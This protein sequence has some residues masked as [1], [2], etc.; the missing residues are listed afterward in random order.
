MT[1]THTQP[2]ILCKTKTQQGLHYWVSNHHI[3]ISTHLIKPMQTSLLNSISRMQFFLSVKYLSPM[4]YHLLHQQ[5]CERQETQV[6]L[7]LLCRN[8]QVIT[9]PCWVPLCDTCDSITHTQK[10]YTRQRPNKAVTI[11]SQMITI[12][13]PLTSSNRCIQVGWI[14]YPGCSSF[15]LLSVCCQ[16]L[17]YSAPV[18]I[19]KTR[20]SIAVTRV[21]SVD[22]PSPIIRMHLDGKSGCS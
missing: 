15:C 20:R 13:Y 6:A 2:E 12:Q 9:L 14:H 21:Y 10:Y 8:A 1:A 17:P 11:G 5:L 16:C 18:A 3:T 22:L 19:W 4:F 7:W